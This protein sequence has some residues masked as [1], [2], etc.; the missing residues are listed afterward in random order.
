MAAEPE[1]RPGVQVFDEISQ[2][3]HL[4]RTIIARSLPV[5]LSYPQFEVLNLLARRG[6]GFAPGA[7]A[8]ALQLTK[9]GLTNTLQ[10]LGSRD[11]IRVETCSADGRKK[12]IWLTADGRKAYSQSMVTIRPKMGSLRE[13][14]TPNEFIAALPFLRALRAWLDE[15]P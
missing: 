6:D 11:L 7:I 8:K 2:I 1:D 12:R 5:G 10:R 3:E 13:A 14:F 9:S 4:M 15:N